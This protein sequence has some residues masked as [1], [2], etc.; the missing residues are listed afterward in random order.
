VGCDQPSASELEGLQGEQGPIGPKGPQGEQ[1]P[2]GPEGPQGEQGAIGPEGPQG[3]QGAIGPE[4]P[5]GEQGPIGPEGPQGEQ[6]IPGAGSTIEYVQFDEEFLVP[7]E[8]FI[9]QPHPYSDGFQYK[10]EDYTVLELTVNTAEGQLV[11]IES[12]VSFYK[13]HTTFY[14]YRDDTLLTDVLVRQ[15]YGP[16]PNSLNWIDTPPPGQHT[17][18]IKVTA[19]AGMSPLAQI[20]YRS[21]IL[22]IFN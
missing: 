4:G 13:R 15:Y 7:E 12:L 3:E 19:D 2:I 5:Q 17:Y 18:K 1:G 9:V 8:E 10:L 21:L 14:L 6:G 11:K 20:F 22:Q 16:K